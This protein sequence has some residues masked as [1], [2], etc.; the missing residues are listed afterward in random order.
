MPAVS[1]VP[2]EGL[3][4][5]PARR[6]VDVGHRPP[7]ITCRRVRRLRLAGPLEVIHPGAVVAL[8]DAAVLDVAPPE[9]VRAGAGDLVL[10]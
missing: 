4:D 10:L 2:I 1:D 9:R 8:G 6:V 7:G 5:A 3:G